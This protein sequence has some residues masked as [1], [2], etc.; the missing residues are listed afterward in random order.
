M[1]LGSNIDADD[2]PARGPRLKP[3]CGTF[4]DTRSFS[5][6]LGLRLLARGDQRDAARQR[7]H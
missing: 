1:P 3:G 5:L 4:R 7:L 6:D 2:E